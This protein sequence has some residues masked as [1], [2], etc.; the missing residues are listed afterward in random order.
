MKKDNTRAAED[1]IDYRIDEGPPLKSRG[2]SMTL[3]SIP[4]EKIARFFKRL[5][6][7]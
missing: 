3:I 4:L 1:S 6:R 5:M 2:A 7:I